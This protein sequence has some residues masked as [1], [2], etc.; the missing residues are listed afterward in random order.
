MIEQLSFMKGLVGRS[1]LLLPT[2]MCSLSA[3]NGLTGIGL[4]ETGYRTRTQTNGPALGFWQMEPFTHD[5]LWKTYLPRHPEISAVLMNTLKGKAPSAEYLETNDTYACL[6]SRVLLYRIP[7]PL[8][9][10]LSATGWASYWK[11]WYNTAQVGGTIARAV[12]LFQRAI[13]AV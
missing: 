4:V 13:T 2:G 3:I 8:P 1:L 11:K 9:N 7:A 6:M 12:P 10:A 5:D